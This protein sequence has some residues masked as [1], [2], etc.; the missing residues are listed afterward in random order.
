MT[1]PRPARDVR[2][3]TTVK[4]IVGTKSRR[5]MLTSPT[6]STVTSPKYCAGSSLHKPSARFRLPLATTQADDQTAV[7]KGRAEG[8]H[9]PV[10]E[11]AA[12]VDRIRGGDAEVARDPARGSREPMGGSPSGVL[13]GEAHDQGTDFGINRWAAWTSVRMGPVPS[14]RRRCQ[15]NQVAGAMRR[16]VRRHRD[17]PRHGRA[18][19][20]FE[21]DGPLA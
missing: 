8:V 20:G 12:S 7:V 3:V 13:A 2:A 1:A 18:E 6:F 16:E 15:R 9:E 17:G 19:G 5:D 11:L 4:P 14:N 10:A 21:I